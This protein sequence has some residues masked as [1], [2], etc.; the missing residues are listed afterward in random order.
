MDEHSKDVVAVIQTDHYQIIQL[1]Q[2]LLIFLQATTNLCSY[3]GELSIVIE[4]LSDG[5][6]AHRVGRVLFG[7]SAFDAALYVDCWILVKDYRD[8]VEDSSVLGKSR[9]TEVVDITLGSFVVPTCKHSRR[10][11]FTRTALNHVSQRL[12]G[13][14]QGYRVCHLSG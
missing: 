2:E 1:C 9:G 3:H 14:V 13:V 6:G 5:N 12:R 8:F 4:V 7:V 11:D 10:T